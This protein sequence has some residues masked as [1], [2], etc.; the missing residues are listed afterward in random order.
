MN[1]AKEVLIKFGI[2]YI[3]ILDEPLIGLMNKKGVKDLTNT[4]KLVVGLLLIGVRKAKVV[5]EIRKENKIHEEN[6]MA[7]IEK[8][9]KAASNSKKNKKQTTVKVARNS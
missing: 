9:A 8:S 7:L 4:E 1:E 2:D 6:L 3:D 5:V